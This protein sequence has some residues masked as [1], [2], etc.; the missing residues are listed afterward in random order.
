M[1]KLNINQLETISKRKEN[2]LNCYQAYAIIK[3][4]SMNIAGLNDH[5]T[6]Y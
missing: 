3:Q 2:H 6:I 5:M 1:D 4:A